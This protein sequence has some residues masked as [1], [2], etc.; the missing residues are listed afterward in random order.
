MKFINSF[1]VLLDVIENDRT[2]F[3]RSSGRYSTR[4]IF[5]DNFT[6][7][8]EL[9]SSLN[10]KRIDLSNLLPS[11]TKWFTSDELIKL[12]QDCDES[13]VIYPLSEILRFYTDRQLQSF[14][15]S[16]F[17]TQN[18]ENKSKRVYIPLVG[19]YEKFSEE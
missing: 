3:D 10:L 2:K 9:I 6:L 5:L 11:P 8:K 16:V 15:T 18:N 4:V 19:L 12:I 1:D 17:E 13:C 7:F 14:L